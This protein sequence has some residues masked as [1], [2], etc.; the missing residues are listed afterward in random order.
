MQNRPEISVVVPTYKRPELLAMCLTSLAHQHLDASRFEVVVVDDGSGSETAAVVQAAE[1][2]LPSLQHFELASNQGPAAARNAGI[3]AAS[4]QLVLLLDD[5]IVASPHL[6]SSHIAF[7]AGRDERLGVVGLVEWLPGLAINPFM[8]WLDTSDVQFAYATMTEG[9]LEHPWEAFY[10]C[11]VSLH[12]DLVVAAGGFDER[13]PYPAYE[14]TELAVRL[15]KLGF[16]LE[17]KPQALA[18]H[19]R[20][21]TVDGFCD[22][23]RK[24]G[25]AAVILTDLQP[26][27]PVLPPTGP[28]GETGWRRL[29]ARL[30]PLA[31]SLARTDSL[32]ARYYQSRLNVAYQQGVIAGRQKLSLQSD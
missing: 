24:V 9:R 1:I 20:E 17:Y 12:R 7:H 16:Q 30:L 29:V 28:V 27:F 10:T 11:N 14:D 4:A 3:A 8:K 22:R 19:A 23:M 21:M 31:A 15:A 13:F 26:D 5:D 2:E 6:L 32:R 18:W 25:E